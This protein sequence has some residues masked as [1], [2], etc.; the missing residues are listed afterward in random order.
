MGSVEV[1]MKHRLIVLFGLAV[2]AAFSQALQFEVASVRPTAP[3]DKTK[4]N[5]GLHLD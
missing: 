2:G 5:L 3:G 1:H 4:V